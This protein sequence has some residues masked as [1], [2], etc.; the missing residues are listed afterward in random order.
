MAR[1]IGIN[2]GTTPKKPVTRIAISGISTAAIALVVRLIIPQPESSGWLAT[3]LTSIGLIEVTEYWTWVRWFE[4]PWFEWQVYKLDAAN[5]GFSFVIAL[6]TLGTG[7]FAYWFF[8][9][10]KKERTDDLGS[11]H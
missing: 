8:F 5:D 1:I 9:L 6:A 11:F 10:R 3:H 2:L 7:I 4:W